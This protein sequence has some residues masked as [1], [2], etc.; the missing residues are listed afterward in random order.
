MDARTDELSNQIPSLRLSRSTEWWC[1]QRWQKYGD[2]VTK[3][4]N[5]VMPPTILSVIII[6]WNDATRLE[7]CLESLQ[8]CEDQINY[9]VIVVDNGSTDHTLTMLTSFPLVKVIQNKRNLGMAP[10]RNIG[11]DH[12]R[13]DYLLF[14][15]SD[16]EI[17]QGC[18]TNAVTAL[19]GQ[20]T[21]WVGGCK[22]FRTDGSLEHSAKRF[23]T[24]STLLFRRTFLGKLFPDA[25]C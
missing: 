9:E 17:H 20:P 14:L 18:L 25:S 8:C 3:I 21:V 11:I 13:G 16:T 15:D 24:L 7:R 19:A 10:A 1:I 4:A 22:T 12:A 2:V 5:F 6:T 23:Y